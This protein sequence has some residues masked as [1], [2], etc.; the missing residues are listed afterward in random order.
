MNLYSG[1]YK[2]H[3]PL[4][5][6]ML[7]AIVV[8]FWQLDKIPFVH[9]ELSALFRTRFDNFTDL[10]NK[11]VLIDGHPAGIQVFLYYWGQFFGFSEIALKI[12]FLIMGTASVGLIYLVGKEWFGKTSGL[13]A[14]AFSVSL[15]YTV[16]YSQIAR[17]YSSGLFFSLLMVYFWDK[18]VYS[19]QKQFLRNSFFYVIAAS[20]CTYNHHFSLLFAVIVGISGLFIIPKQFLRKYFINGILIFVLYL[21]HISILLYQLKVGGVEGW[22]GKPE[23]D[24]LFRYI[25]FLFNYSFL[26]LAFAFCLFLFGVISADRKI[27][28]QKYVL[29]LMWFFLPLFIGFFYSK[30]VNSVLQYSVLIFSFPFFLYILFGSIKELSCKV[31]L[32]LVILIL[33]VSTTTLVFERRHYELFYKSAYEQILIDN[34]VAQTESKE[35]IVS[36]I[37]SHKLISKYYIEKH[38]LDST[39]IWDD[40]FENPVSLILFLEKSVASND[41]LFFGTMNSADQL[42]VAVI[43]KYYPRIVRHNCYFGGES[44][45]FS[46][47]VNSI[48]GKQP[49]SEMGFEAENKNWSPINISN[50]IDSVSFFGNYSL[51]LNE[52]SEWSPSFSYPMDSLHLQK[53]DVIE[54]NL[55]T[56][57]ISDTI[58][59][60]LVVSVEKDGKSLIWNG[61]SFGLFVKNTQPEWQTVFN[62]IELNFSPREFKHHQMK[63]Y[64]WNKGKHTFLI[65]N[66]KIQVREGNRIKY[67]LS[68]DLN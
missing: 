54:V 58:D 25:H 12:P 18:L 53:F 16:F 42:T 28:T 52:K 15:Q 23:N 31:N 39:F 62:A 61:T 46:K 34:Q 30:F 22:L 67:G 63:V 11:G 64:V 7:V 29:S 27:F 48:E 8:R 33:T 10:I 19:P 6:I 9:D 21:P 45:L 60:V 3:L 44:F 55:K 50:R 26:L 24:F 5:L 49:L 59:A 57:I 2:N 65:D 36:I 40:H 32:L 14:A 17:P 38:Q 56:K 66:I 13:I 43:R 35:K 68:E 47:E 20:L 51:L 4:F 1:K 37:H 41:Y